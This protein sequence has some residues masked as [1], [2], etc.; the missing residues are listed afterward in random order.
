M[1]GFIKELEKKCNYLEVREGPPSYPE[2]SGISHTLLILDDQYQ[3][4]F[5]SLNMQV[6]MSRD[7]HHKK[8]SKYEAKKFFPYYF[9][10]LGVIWTCQC[11][12]EKG[13]YG[14]A[15]WKNSY[16][17]VFFNDRSDMHFMSRTSSS[18]CPQKNSRLFHMCF[19]NLAE[20]YPEQRPYI[21]V[22]N[23]PKS[24]FKQ[25]SVISHIFPFENEEGK[26]DN[27]TIEPLFFATKTS[28][29]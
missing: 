3:D 8:I 14:N 10:V 19:R 9:C 25:V 17:W 12:Q 18:I 29:K 23:N 28:K 21:L 26:K 22:D 11:L 2:V 20:N 6:L 16:Y 1:D 15:I 7:S 27:E 24:L 13:R 5:Q 4:M